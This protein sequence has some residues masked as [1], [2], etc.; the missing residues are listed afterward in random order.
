MLDEAVKSDDNL[1]TALKELGKKHQ[2]FGVLQE[3]YQILGKALFK[4]LHSSLEDQFTP[5][6]RQAWVS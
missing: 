2:E 1:G 3:H 4:T 5:H 6:V